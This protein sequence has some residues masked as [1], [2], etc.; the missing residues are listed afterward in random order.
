MDVY[1]VLKDYIEW[2]LCG[3]HRIVSEF[4]I[5]D[6]TLDIQLKNCKKI[7]PKKIDVDRANNKL[8]LFV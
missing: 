5:P 7:S 6:T 8:T 4:T 2:S 1:I 3:T